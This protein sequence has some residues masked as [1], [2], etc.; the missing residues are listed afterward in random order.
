MTEYDYEREGIQA[1]NIAAHQKKMTGDCHCGK[2]R[3]KHSNVEGMRCRRKK[4][5]LKGGGV[6]TEQEINDARLRKI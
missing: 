1:K 5:S 6:L 4:E 3:M 2:P